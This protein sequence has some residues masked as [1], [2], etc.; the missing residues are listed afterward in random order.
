MASVS[1]AVTSLGPAS[2]ATGVATNASVTVTFNEAL[3]VTTINSGTVYLSNGGAA[4]A[5]TVTYNAAN[6]TVTLTPASALASGTTYTVNVIGG[7]SGIKDPAGDA[8]PATVVSSFTTAAAAVTTTTSSLWSTSVTPAIV[9]SGDTQAAEVGIKFTP[10][11]SGFITGVRYYKSAANTGTHTGSLW[12][13]GGQLLAT[14]TF[15][16]EGTSG[17]QTVLFSNPVPVTAGT[18]YVAS[19]HTNAGPLRGE[20]LLLHVVLHGRRHSPCPPAAASTPTAPAASPPKPTRQATI[21]STSSSPPEPR[22]NPSRPPALPTAA[23]S[24]VRPVERGLS[25]A[26]ARCLIGFSSAVDCGP[27]RGLASRQPAGV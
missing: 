18:T 25:A 4:V 9:D 6:N 23:S 27:F 5:A 2:G 13:A 19:Y 17:W 10:N 7:T 15:T 24:A 20:P 12:T 16:G 21:G 26:Q 3:D 22:Q 8:L 11:T 1:P 14:A